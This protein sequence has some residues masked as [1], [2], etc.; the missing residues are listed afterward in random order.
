MPSP[1][2]QDPKPPR[3]VHYLHSSNQIPLRALALLPAQHDHSQLN[4]SPRL[5]ISSTPNDCQCISHSWGTLVWYDTESREPPYK[6]RNLPHP[7][8][9]ILPLH[10]QILPRYLDTSTLPSIPNNEAPGRPRLP[11]SFPSTHFQKKPFRSPDT[12]ASPLSTRPQP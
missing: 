10:N 5:A 6:A 3:R 11:S 4:S 9:Q 7:P 2:S 8:N 1:Q 12:T